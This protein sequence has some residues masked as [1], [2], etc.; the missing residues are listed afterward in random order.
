MESQTVVRTYSIQNNRISESVAALDIK[1]TFSSLMHSMKD[2]DSPAKKYLNPEI[3]RDKGQVLSNKR[4]ESLGEIPTI[5]Y[6]NYYTQTQRWLGTIHEINED[7]FNAKLEDLN[8]GG[9]N[10][11]AEFS[12]SEVSKE[13]VSLITLGGVFYWSVGYANYKGQVKKESIIRFQRLPQWT[14]EDI[15][16][17]VDQVREE[18]KNSKW[19]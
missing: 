3:I 17:V 19:L 13:D 14:T 7:C 4:V 16:N 18:S 11:F 10:E 9:T 2:E 1:K 6:K 12:F 8:V 5:E 15:D